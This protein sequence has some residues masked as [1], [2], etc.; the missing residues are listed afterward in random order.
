[1]RKNINSHVAKAKVSIFVI[2]PFVETPS[3]DKQSLDHFF[4]VNLKDAIE[5]ERALSNSYTVFRSEDA[6]DITSKI[7]SDLYEADIVICDLSGEYANPNV[8]YELGVRLAISNSPVILIR[9]SSPCNKKIF[10]IS[11]FYTHEYNP[12]R[13]QDLQIFLIDKLKKIELGFDVF[14]SPVLRTLKQSPNVVK[15]TGEHQAL[16]ILELAQGAL[17]NIL[18]LILGRIQIHFSDEQGL[19]SSK[20]VSDVI[21][22]FAAENERLSRLNWSELNINLHKPPMLELVLAQIRLHDH[23]PHRVAILVNTFVLDYIL[24]FFSGVKELNSFTNINELIYET[25]ELAIVLGLCREYIA[26]TDKSESK[27]FEIIDQINR[28]ALMIHTLEGQDAHEQN[29]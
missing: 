28:S 21:L 24:Y 20:D 3:R 8:M 13:Y 25:F 6:F 18:R 17:N 11:G 5:E 26:G 10:D 12:L 7:I 19:N 27:V 22:F 29:I 15:I 2:M 9:E 4:Q 23:L 1:M 14:E 16:Q